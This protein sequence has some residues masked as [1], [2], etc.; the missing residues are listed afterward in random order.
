[1]K[2]NAAKRNPCDFISFYRFFSLSLDD[3]ETMAEWMTKEHIWKIP[4]KGYSV[5]EDCGRI[6]KISLLTYF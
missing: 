1:M 6:R 4:V 2:M 5:N 3:T